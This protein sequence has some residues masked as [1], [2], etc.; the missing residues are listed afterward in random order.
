MV[1]KKTKNTPQGAMIPRFRTGAS[2][3]VRKESRP[4]AV[5]RLVIRIAR[6]EWPKA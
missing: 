2:S 3:A 5:V 6:P 4:A 1:K